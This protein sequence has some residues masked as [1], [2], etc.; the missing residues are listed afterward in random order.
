M[1]TR[2]PS[3]VVLHGYSAAN[4]GD[5]L[6]VE[7]A[8]DVVRQV[9][10]D[11]ADVTVVANHPETFRGLPVTVVDSGIRRR[12]VSRDYLRLLRSLDRYDL[13][14]G[15]GGGYLRF[16]RPLEA[17]KAGLVHLPQLAAAARTAA[18]TVYLPQSVGPLRGPS[19]PVVRRLLRGVDVV[20][21]RD[22]RTVA[23]LA[24]GNVVRTSDLALGDIDVDRRGAL[25][26]DEAAL[27]VLSVRYVDGGITRP[28]ARLAEAM[29]PFDGYVQST[30][31]ANDDR[32]AM[33]S[34][35]PGTTLGYDELVGS[36]ASAR[37]VV[38]V[39]MHA[40]LMAIRAGHY[41]VHLSYERKGFAAFGDLGLSDLVHN[42]RSLDPAVVAGQVRA[43]RHD[44]GARA[45]YDRRMAEAV[46]TFGPRRAQ[47]VEVVRD[48]V[49]RAATEVPA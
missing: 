43:L 38:A 20:L 4:K 14:L 42:V 37:V 12:G 36:P 1:T 23:E 39:R 28:L 46:A 10:G 19:R 35:A 2:R 24:L 33:A 6:L 17:V 44:P 25:P 22:D 5:G 45:D 15:V 48:R 18:P 34:L 13:V 11:E 16:G 7:H 26:F 9:L 49:A 47:V 31:G 27:P 29:R 3:A 32:A 8:L 41:V 21:A 30:A 40:A